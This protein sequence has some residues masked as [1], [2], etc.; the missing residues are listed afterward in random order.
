MLTGTVEERMRQAL[1]MTSRI[2]ALALVHDVPFAH[3]SNR[4]ALRILQRMLE[5]TI[6]VGWTDLPGAL[7]WV[8]LVGAAAERGQG[9]GNILTAYLSTTCTY[10][11]FRHWDAVREILVR[12]LAVEDQLDARAGRQT[13]GEDDPLD[14]A[15][16]Y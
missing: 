10:M 12:F 5:S 11:G 14:M 1:R 9:E 16:P 3:P 8:L 2:Y 15:L 6:L 7:L 13:R 4:N